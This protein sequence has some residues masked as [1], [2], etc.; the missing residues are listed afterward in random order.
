MKPF[1]FRIAG[2]IALVWFFAVAPVRA[3]VTYSDSFNINVNYLTNGLS[4]T[5]WDGVY[6]GAGDFD[7]SGLGGSGPGATLQCDANSSRAN[8]L[9]LQTTGTDWEGTGDDGFFLFKVAPG[10]FSMSVHVVSPFNNGAYNTAGL[11]ARA[12]SPG[13]DPFG[14]SEN[15]VSWTRFDEFSFANYLRNEAGGSV[16]QIN[17]GNF[18]NT[19]YW[20]RIDRVQGTNFYFYEKGANTAAW[21]LRTFPA[22]VS[23][24][25]LRRSD[26]AR[27]PMQVGII[28]A[29]F[30][31]QLG[32]Q[33]TD[34]SLT[35]SNVLYAAPP[36][37]P[38]WVIAA[39]NASPGVDI[40]WA[41]AAGSSGSVV[42]MWPATN[43]VVKEMPA[44]GVTYSG[45]AS[46]G[47]GSQLPAAG[48]YVVYAGTGTNVS[49]NNLVPNT[50]YDIAVFSYAGSGSSISYNHSPA[51]TSLFLPPNAII[52]QLETQSGNLNVSFSANPGKWYWLQYSDSLN[53]PNWQNLLP[54][55]VFAYS[56]VMSIEGIV[57]D[58]APQRFYRLRQVDPEFATKV[59][60]GT[61]S[62]LQHMDD[63]ETTEYISGGKLGNARVTYQPAG[64]S[65]WFTANTA[66][67]SG[68]A[69]TT[70]S[71]ITNGGG[72]QYTARYVL[73]AGLSG[74]L[75]FESVLTMKQ[76]NVQWS[77]NFTNLTGQ[78][79]TIGDLAL[80]LPMNT[81]FSGVSSSAMKHSFIS[82]YGSFI[83]WMRPDSVPPYLLM[84]PSD[85]TKLEFWDDPSAPNGYEVYVHSAV[86][87]ANAAAQFPSV[88]TGGQ[89][90]RQPN[91]SLAL[92]PGGS[93]SY[94]FKFQW[95]NGYDGVRQ[96]L[97][98]NGKIDV[99]VIPGMT[100]PTN[101]FAEIALR[102]TQDIAS[103]TAEFPSETQIQ[104]LGTTNLAAGA[105]QLYQV[106]FSRL[107][108]NELTI[109]YG[110]NRTMFLEFFVTEPIETLIKKRAAFLV[111]HQII[112]NQWYSGLFC[113]ENMNDGQLIT[114]DNHDT[115]GNSFQ[116][117]EIASDDAGESRPAYMATKEAVY[118]VQSEV[119]ALDYYITNFVWGGLQR[120]TNETDSYAI[121]GVP[122]WHTLR[123]QNN[124]SIGRGYDYPHIIV[125]YYEMYR[126]AKYH[127][128]VTTALSAQEYLQRAWGTA[129]ALWKYG[130]GQATQIGLMNEVVIPDLI[131]ALV[132]EG[133]LSQAASLRANWENKVAYY[134]SGSANLFGSEYAFDATGFES[135]EAYAKYA[136]QRAGTSA[137]MGS[138]NVAQFLNQATNFMYDQI[139][140]NMFD[141]GW[142]ETAY[143]YYG[144]DY[145]GD[146]GDDFVDTYMAQMGGWGLLDFALNYA[147]NATDYLRLGYGSYLNG[148]STM[149]TGTPASNYGFWYPGAQYDGGCGGGFEPS[150]DNYTWLGGQPM[151][152]G[153]WYYS[154]E[155]NLGFC[156]AI[157]SAATILADDPIFGR[158][159]YGGAWT[160]VAND[161]QITPLDG[162]RRRFH[163]LLNSGTM[164]LVL[165]SDHF[166]AGQSLA[167][168][169][170]LSHVNF[171]VET[172]N[173]ETHSTS[174]DF[175]TTVAGAYTLSDDSGTLATII[176]QA[177]QQ[178][179]FSLPFA[180]GGSTK[181]FSIT[182]Q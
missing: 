36:S 25:V 149:N 77:L 137:A 141:R 139:T 18:P 166:T 52:A 99:H 146:M 23:G 43:S 174:L 160:N 5:I 162:V 123:T 15:F 24:S 81:G 42:V 19:N 125:M 143:Y 71:S 84:T 132:A 108:E 163:A 127:P 72:T 38:Q 173:T 11:Q 181:T 51:V 138:G 148:W 17:P 8:T 106:Q 151:H 157:R 155:E 124:L 75:I 165:E 56:P 169:P 26:L 70:Y 44:N 21:Q 114:P 135:Q 53:P 22:P 86:S 49:V 73:T 113:D 31:G 96:A 74:Q 159:C 171:T 118:P 168:A 48:Y 130:G 13:G 12:F 144:S 40:S 82:G 78:S 16:A 126:V 94:G 121:Y 177:D 156:G 115:L 100:V 140:A 58:S 87:A 110:N 39:P 67:P 89:R 10:D 172:G 20:L 91:T 176:L 90:W 133:M 128:E 68:I 9:T 63:A 83:F 76:D 28:H 102:T 64:S 131:N 120:T 182:K 93:Q 47:A 107:G 164:H 29:T 14:G 61:V 116:V 35:L 66:T 142:L 69:S 50:A 153:A 104:F 37:A 62:S 103:V 45:N 95:A 129:D 59:S 154:A 60:L 2:V 34:F 46:Y 54:D 88:T 147:T 117:Y 161:I 105:Y 136:L 167:L 92:A 179:V 97:V 55:P 178:T 57:P 111:S 170:D 30:N 109:T 79:L 32:V 145:R 6:F 85:D 152:R 41:P 158:F 7:N 134:V 65:S 3:R 119:S 33:F 98:D 175:S 27:Q 112:T 150:P 80:P 101:L 122:D 180:S 4:G 1:L